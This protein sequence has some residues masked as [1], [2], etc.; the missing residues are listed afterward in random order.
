MLPT[1]IIIA[2]IL[3]KCGL[4]YITETDDEFVRNDNISWEHVSTVL[5]KEREQSAK[6]FKE[7]L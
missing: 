3:N 5:K 4:S 7:V 2:N 6:Y 1:N